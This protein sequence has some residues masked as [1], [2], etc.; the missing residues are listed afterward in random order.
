VRRAASLLEKNGFR[1]RFLFLLPP[2]CA[3]LPPLVCVVETSIY[4]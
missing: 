4:R 2:Q 1:V 3:K